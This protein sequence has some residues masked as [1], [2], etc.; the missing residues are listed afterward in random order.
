MKKER[1]ITIKTNIIEKDKV[2]NYLNENGFDYIVNGGFLFYT[3][4]IF[5]KKPRQLRSL[6]I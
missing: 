3:I 2:I 1:Y 5:Y 4:D 6:V